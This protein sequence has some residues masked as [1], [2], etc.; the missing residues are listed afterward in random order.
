[1]IRFGSQSHAE[2]AFFSPDGTSLLSGS[3]D[4]FVEVGGSLRRRRVSESSVCQVW[5]FETCKLRRDL[6]YQV[7]PQHTLTQIR[8]SLT[9]SLTHIRHSHS[10]TSSLTRIRHSLTF[11]TRSHSSPAHTITDAKSDIAHTITQTHTLSV[12]RSVGLSL[13]LSSVGVNGTSGVQFRHHH[14]L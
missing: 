4:G 12:G 9:S 13:S 7:R 5:D 2:T 11:V 3:V 1:M 8:H 6:P 10:L 14:E